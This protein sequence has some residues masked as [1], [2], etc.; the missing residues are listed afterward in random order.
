MM[1]APESQQIDRNSTCADT[2]EKVLDK[3]PYCLA[4]TGAL[5]GFGYGSYIGIKVTAC[6]AA[7]RTCLFEPYACDCCMLAYKSIGCYFITA[8]T[9]LAGGAAPLCALLIPTC[10]CLAIATRCFTDIPSD[11]SETGERHPVEANYETAS[12]AFT[13]QGSSPCT[14]TFDNE[15]CATFQPTDSGPRIVKGARLSRSNAHLEPGRNQ[16]VAYDH[17]SIINRAPPCY[18]PP[19]YEDLFGPPPSYESLQNSGTIPPTTR[20]TFGKQN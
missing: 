12:S 17:F 5:A 2:C 1:T 10:C 20:L 13:T 11:T 7:C 3:L 14:V 6:D 15:A 9:T 18:A 16:S 4:N 19:S 8:C